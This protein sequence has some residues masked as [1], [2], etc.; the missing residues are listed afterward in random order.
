MNELSKTI[1]MADAGTLANHYASQQAF[2]EYQK[3]KSNNTLRAHRFDLATFTAYLAD[4]KI[5]P[6]PTGKA[7]QSTPEAWRGVT[8]GIVEGFRNW[9][10]GQ[11]FSVATVNRKL[12]T[13]KVY[14]GLA[15]KAGIVAKDEN[16]LIHAVATYAPKETNRVNEKRT[17]TRKSNKKAINTKLEPAQ[18]GQLKRN[19]PDTPQGKRDAL[20]MCLLLDHGLRVGELAALKV[21]DFKGKELEFH[22]E[23]VQITQRHRLSDDTQKAWAAYKDYAIPGGLLLRKS[24]KS[25]ELGDAGMSTRSVWNRVGELGKKIGVEN[26]GPHDC[27]HYWATRAVKGGTDPFKLMQAGGWTSMQTVQKYVDASAIANDGVTLSEE[28]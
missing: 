3:R 1:S 22:R 17:V 20:I 16:T 25:E 14:A 13:V 15:T 23:K 11:G 27:R 5:S 10:L 8:W 7:L 12:K 26:L 6:L 24:L 9:M 2:D 18:A 4:A 19:Q 21:T 28:E